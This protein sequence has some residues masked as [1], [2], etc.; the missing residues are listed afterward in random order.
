MHFGFSATEAKW[1]GR[2]E[3]KSGVPANLVP[4][5]QSGPQGVSSAGL[6]ACLAPSLWLP[7]SSYARAPLPRLSPLEAE[8]KEK[9]KTYTFFLLTD[10]VAAANSSG[11]PKTL[12]YR[13]R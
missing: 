2:W 7:A 11:G 4:L 3:T 8:L 5:C 1:F 12:M 13:V 6:P 9:R 10:D